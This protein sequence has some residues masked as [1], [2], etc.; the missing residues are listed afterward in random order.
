MSK[1]I[2]LRNAYL[3]EFDF[4]CSRFVFL[5]ERRD[6]RD[7]ILGRDGW[8][9]KG[10]NW[11]VFA[12]EF[13]AATSKWLWPSGKSESFKSDQEWVVSHSCGF[14]K[15]LFVLQ[16]IVS[17]GCLIPNFVYEFFLIAVDEKI[18]VTFDFIWFS[19]PFFRLSI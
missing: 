12:L 18:M 17:K 1:M 9:S 15:N 8:Q 3:F 11:I 7:K 4:S 13:R 14:R 10:V 5:Q 19:E 2:K 6:V 16:S